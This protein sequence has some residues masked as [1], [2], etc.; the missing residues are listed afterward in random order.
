MKASKKKQLEFER[1]LERVI[2]LKD[3]LYGK[4]NWSRIYLPKDIEGCKAYIRYCKE[5]YNLIG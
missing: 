2:L 5:N 3:S 4:N 1:L